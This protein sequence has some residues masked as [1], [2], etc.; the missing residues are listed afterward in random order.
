MNKK[1]QILDKTEE[2]LFKIGVK[3]T[4]MDDISHEI[5]ISKKTLYDYF[6]TKEAL[7][8]ET[9]QSY[10]TKIDQIISSINKKNVNAVEK[11]FTI[12]EN[13]TS[14][15]SFDEVESRLINIKK[16]YPEIFEEI[17]LK[18]LK[19]IQN[20]FRK[21]I[22][23]GIL[24]GLFRED[25]DL[26]LFIKFYYIGAINMCG[27]TLFEGTNMSYKF[28]KIKYLEFYIRSISTAKGIE[29]IEEIIPS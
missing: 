18:Q 14:T 11:F 6:P 15:V 24:E 16:Y 26:N 20:N 28:L 13:T 10:F 3:S 23:Q 27:N 19:I 8:R 22:L 29:K 25:F 5:G 21:I 2:L 17:Q 1:K 12:I 7:V 4:T 9:L